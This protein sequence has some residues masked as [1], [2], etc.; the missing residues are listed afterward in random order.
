MRW[1]Y[2]LYLRA[3]GST[4]ILVANKCDGSI[5]GFT[6]TAAIVEER[7]TVLRKEWLEGRG[8]SS[9]RM[10]TDITVLERPSL[11]SCRDGVGLQEMIDRIA[12]QGA[13]SVRVPPAWGL[14]LTFLDALRDSR[15]PQQACRD[16]LGLGSRPK[17]GADSEPGS[18]FFSEKSL[19]EQW[20]G[21]VQNVEGELRSD[22][23]KMAVSDPDSAIEGALWIR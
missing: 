22:A 6:G 10:N 4:V 18:S 20:K 15:D 1:L 23:E 11:V 3:P 21:V 9:T 16:C 12:A 2:V 5:E 19:V 8:F 17:V 13:V 7:V 14:A